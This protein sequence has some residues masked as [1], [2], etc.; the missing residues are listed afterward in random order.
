MSFFQQGGSGSTL[1]LMITVS[2]CKLQPQYPT[3]LNARL[4]TSCSSYSIRYQFLLSCSNSIAMNTLFTVRYF[5]TFFLKN[6][7]DLL[8]EN[9]P[10]YFT[11]N[12]SDYPANPLLS[13]KTSLAHLFTFFFEKKTTLRVFLLSLISRICIRRLS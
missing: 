1:A 3:A 7:G 8:K 9:P 6:S 10:P 11:F 5:Q 13:K 4:N 12:G 2:T